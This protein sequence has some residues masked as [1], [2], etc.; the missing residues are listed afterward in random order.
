M[1]YSQ[2]RFGLIL[3]NKIVDLLKSYPQ[4]LTTKEIQKLLEIKYYLPTIVH[5][6]DLLEAK[7]FVKIRWV[8]NN[9]LIYY[10]EGY[11]RKGVVK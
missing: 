7:G 11:R 3:E 1:R 9:K 2:E 4:G 6:I 10:K 5:K 8:G